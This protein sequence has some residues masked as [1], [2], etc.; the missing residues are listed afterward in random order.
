LQKEMASADIKL[1][2]PDQLLQIAVK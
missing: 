1:A 2:I